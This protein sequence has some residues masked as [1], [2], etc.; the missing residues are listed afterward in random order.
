VTEIGNKPFIKCEQ[1]QRIV[2]RG[3]QPPTLKSNGSEKI[4]L[5]VPRGFASLYKKAKNW[6]KFKTIIEE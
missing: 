3:A 6:K 2:C 4:P 1:L 5:Y